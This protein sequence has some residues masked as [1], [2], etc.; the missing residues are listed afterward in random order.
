MYFL[1]S[2]LLSFSIMTAAAQ[3]ADNWVYKGEE[4]G[5]KIYHQRAD[6]LLHIKLATSLKAPLAGIAALFAEV[7]S[8]PK[9]GYKMVEARM[10]HRVSETEMYYYARYD[11]PWPIEDR[12]IILHSKLEQNQKSKTIT[13]VN[14]PK[15]D[16]LPLTKGVQRIQ[17]TTTQWLFVPG[18][19]GWVYTE[20]L[21]STDSAEGIPDWLVK[22]T[23][24]TGPRET[25]RGI[26]KAL[27]AERFQTAK[28]VH[29]QEK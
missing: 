13:I 2:L 15:P 14:T 27:K 29:I 28:L 16:Y 6:G 24:D 20:Q 17:N 22:M 11:F 3:A 21:I 23:A 10:L 5:I 9:W 4:T 26:Q 8:Y 19:G 7:S 1:T 25:A 12:D 18:N